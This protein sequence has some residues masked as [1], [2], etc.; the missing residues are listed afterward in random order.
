[1]RKAYWIIFVLLMLFPIV[2]DVHLV[3]NYLPLL[4]ESFP[5]WKYKPT[6]F[7]LSDIL[8]IEG[9]LLLVAGAILAGFTLYT[10]V[11]PEKLKWMYVKEVFNW[12]TIKKEHEI[13]ATLKIGLVLISVGIIYISTAIIITL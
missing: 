8:F 4:Q 7:V 6:Y 12:K 11:V 10:M 2:I 5:F 1:L 9:A 13:S 3:F